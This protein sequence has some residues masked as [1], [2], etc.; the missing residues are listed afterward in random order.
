VKPH[1]SND[2]I[3]CFTTNYISMYNRQKYVYDKSFGA[4]KLIVLSWTK[5]AE[6]VIQITTYHYKS[7]VFQKQAHSKKRSFTMHNTTLYYYLEKTLM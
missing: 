7:L 5:H 4:I 1:I 2:K 6:K 3:N